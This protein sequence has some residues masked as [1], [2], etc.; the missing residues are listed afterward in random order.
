MRIGT[1]WNK[2]AP[3]HCLQC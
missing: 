3:G 2:L 1:E